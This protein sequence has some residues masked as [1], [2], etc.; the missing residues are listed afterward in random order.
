MFCCH[1]TFSICIAFSQAIENIVFFGSLKKIQRENSIMTTKHGV[2]VLHTFDNGVK[3]N[4]CAVK[5]II[6]YF[7][8][9]ILPGF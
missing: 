6:V 3:S 1:Y 9:K 2:P 8:S 5:A 7:Q 4:R